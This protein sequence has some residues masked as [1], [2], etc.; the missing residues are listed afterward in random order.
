MS[1]FGSHFI[2]TTVYSLDHRLQ[3][4]KR[5]A[6][7]NL[8]S[9]KS[10]RQATHRV[11]YLVLLCL[12]A[13]SRVVGR[14]CLLH[15]TSTSDYSTRGRCGDRPV[16]FVSVDLCVLTPFYNWKHFFFTNVLKVSIGRDFAALRKCSMD[17]FLLPLLCCSSIVGIIRLLR[18]DFKVRQL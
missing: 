13:S 11:S 15:H 10:L 9:R 16:F 17:Y 1:P 2:L 7:S 3:T 8:A 4:K 12:T 5:P 6:R 18:S 14:T